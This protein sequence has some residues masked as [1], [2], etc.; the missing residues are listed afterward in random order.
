MHSGQ[1]TFSYY[2]ASAAIWIA[3]GASDAIIYSMR[4]GVK[5]SKRQ[6]EGRG[7]DCRVSQYRIICV[8]ASWRPKRRNLPSH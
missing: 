4:P 2:A 3:R 5:W 1:S 7:E 6:L 8:H